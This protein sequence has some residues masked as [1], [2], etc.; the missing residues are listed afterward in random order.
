MLNNSFFG[1]LATV[2]LGAVCFISC[3]TDFNSIGTDIVG[4]DHFGV[5]PTL[6]DVAANSQKTGAVQS[7]NLPI[8]PLGIFDNGAFGKTTANFATQV[9]LAVVAPTFKGVDG[10]DKITS[11]ILDIPYYSTLL[12]TDAEGASTYEL[13]SVYGDIT[14]KLKLK[15]HENGYF[16]RDLDP[17]GEFQNA[18][19]FY[20]DQN[21]VFNAAKGIQL[22]NSTVPAE[23][24]A[25]VFSAKQL[26]TPG[27][28]ED[29]EDVKSAPG[30]RLNLDKQFFYTKIFATPSANLANNNAFKNHFKGLYFN[31]E[32]L[33]GS[34][35]ALM[36]FAQGKI[37]ITYKNLKATATG[38]TD[39]DYEDKTL[40]INL[41]G[42]TVSLLQHTAT[43][44]STNYESLTD[45]SD[46]TTQRL[47]LKGGEGAVT[48][49]DLFG[50]GNSAQLEEIRNT[51][52]ANNWLVNEANLV[53]TVDDAESTNSAM[54]N[55]LDPNRIYLYNAKDNIPI[56]DYYYDTSTFASKPKYSK[57]IHGGI[58]E[59][60][61]VSGDANR[62]AKR[63]KI[64]IT[65]H[66]KNVLFRDSTNVKLGLGV[67]ENIALV[68]NAALKNTSG[69]FTKI[70]TS[71]VMSPTGVVLY[72]SQ[73]APDKENKKLRLEI[74]YTKP[75]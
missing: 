56:I 24:D 59:L 38:T 14:R 42:N 64:R 55:T 50:G 39:S 51:A 4:D 1:K 21:D 15:V 72:G 41:T 73:V 26:I 9:Q 36:N 48:Y 34:T 46:P 5:D 58:A 2:L 33:D 23:N 31:A 69:T 27:K 71:S 17:A 7:N 54:K 52:I 70:P 29:D 35:M 65:E 18:Q 37:T 62:K 61:G 63:Y 68:T 30:M 74:Y 45:L 75:N 40:V 12:T 8:N 47:Y 32:E 43:A 20:T 66:I 44:A 49:I 22:N 13:D 53:F 67:T 16:M 25:F 19:K 28:E 57:G 3:D 11:V 60:T 6:Y 10:I